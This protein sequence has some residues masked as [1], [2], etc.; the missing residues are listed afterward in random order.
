MDFTHRE[1]PLQEA[2]LIFFRLVRS[3]ALTIAAAGFGYSL[4][5]RP[6]ST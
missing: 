2:V 3:V 1:M 4:R 5:Q 6:E